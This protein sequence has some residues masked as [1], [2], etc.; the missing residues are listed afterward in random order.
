MFTELHGCAGE[1]ALLPVWSRFLIK[2]IRNSVNRWCWRAAALPWT[3]A[4]SKIFQ[5]TATTVTSC[6]LHKLPVMD[7]SG[8]NALFPDIFQVQNILWYFYENIITSQINISISFCAVIIC[9]SNF[10]KPSSWMPSLEVVCNAVSI[11][12]VCSFGVLWRL[13]YYD[14]WGRNTHF[15]CSASDLSALL[16]KLCSWY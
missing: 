3:A 16:H 13:W 4:Q 2:I 14:L 11:H 10:F 7:T 15:T 6:W 12:V 9:L 1:A 8:D 5:R